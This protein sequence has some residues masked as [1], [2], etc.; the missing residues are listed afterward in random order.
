MRPTP[1]GKAFSFSI[2]S[3]GLVTFRV[4]LYSLVSSLFASYLFFELPREVLKSLTVITDLSISPL[5]P[6]GLYIKHFE[7]PLLGV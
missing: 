1:V 4:F 2:S 6:V 3:N 5:G 7:A